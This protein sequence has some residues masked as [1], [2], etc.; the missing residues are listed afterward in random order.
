MMIQQFFHIKSHSAYEILSDV[1]RKAAYDRTGSL[2]AAD[3]PDNIF[4]QFSFS[5]P[6]PEDVEAELRDY[7]ESG[8]QLQ[9]VKTVS[10]EHSYRLRD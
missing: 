5:R 10:N 8:E 3:D 2:N 7:A 4:A 9:E 6:K 1:N